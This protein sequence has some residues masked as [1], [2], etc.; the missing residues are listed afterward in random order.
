M[1]G[2]AVLGQEQGE[3]RE[4]PLPAG[5]ATRG[6]R[7]GAEARLLAEEEFVAFHTGEAARRPVAY[8]PA[9]GRHEQPGDARAAERHPHPPD[10]RLSRRARA[11]SR[12]CGPTWTGASR[13]RPQVGE[14]MMT[15]QPI[16]TAKGPGE[17]PQEYTFLT[18]DR[19]NVVK[20]GEFVYY[21]TAGRRRRA[22]GDR[23]GWCSAAPLAS[24]R[25]SSPPT[26]W[27]PPPRWPPPW[28]TLSERWSCSR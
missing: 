25:T 11:P 2:V 9:P 21:R 7:V 22:G 5:G 3:G 17:K 10:R 23:H 27:C 18:P 20:V 26:P 19:D 1:V 16:G 24:T 6:R 8:L 12:C 14:E 13:V 4:R 15:Q 28:A